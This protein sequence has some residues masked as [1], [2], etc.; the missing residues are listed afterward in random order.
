MFCKALKAFLLLVVHSV[1][2]VR[3][4]KCLKQA[5]RMRVRER[6]RETVGECEKGDSY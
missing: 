4:V 5:G 1:V 6:E 2:T 3:K